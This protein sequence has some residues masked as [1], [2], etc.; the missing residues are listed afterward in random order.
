MNSD[1]M[2]SN[3]V[4]NNLISGHW[5]SLTRWQQVSMARELMTIRKARQEYEPGYGDKEQHIPALN[6]STAPVL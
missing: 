5:K 1:S 2:V 3:R 4:L 6:Q